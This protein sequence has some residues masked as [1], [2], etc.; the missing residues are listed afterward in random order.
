MAK[1]LGKD[2]RGLFVCRNCHGESEASRDINLVGN[3]MIFSW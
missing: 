3:C 2:S 1:D